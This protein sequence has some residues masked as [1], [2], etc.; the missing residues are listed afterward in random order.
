MFC[1]PCIPKVLKTAFLDCNP[2]FKEIEEIKEVIEIYQCISGA[3]E[4]SECVEVFLEDGST[5][6]SCIL[7]AIYPPCFKT[8][9]VPKKIIKL[10]EVIECVQSIC[11]AITCGPGA[12]G[13]LA[14]V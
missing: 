11:T 2:Y 12:P 6:L 3:I 10:I 9:L 13:R 8:R 1:D 4:V 5:K 7:K 14:Q